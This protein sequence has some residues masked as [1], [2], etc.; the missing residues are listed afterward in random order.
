[1]WHGKFPR[2]VCLG[3]TALIGAAGMGIVTFG[4]T[5]E[6]LLTR[7][8]SQALKSVPTVWERRLTGD[9]WLSHAPTAGTVPGT[10]LAT[11]QPLR[12]ALAVGDQIKISGRTGTEETIEVTTLEEFDG[13]SLGLTGL[14][15]QMVTGRPL[16]GIP[17]ET[18]RFL[19]AVDTPASDRAP[20]KA[21]SSL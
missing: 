2:G 17:G 18:I 11:A 12:H 19:F 16:A 5:P 7:S 20:V 6:A 8:Y 4:G 15:L 21:D 14:H 3:L 9:L 13:D 1:M 10:G